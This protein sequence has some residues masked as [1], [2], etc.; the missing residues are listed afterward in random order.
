VASCEVKG[1]SVDVTFTNGEKGSFEY[2][3]VA[4]GREPVIA[5]SVL[6]MWHCLD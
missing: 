2:V 4:I 1:D 6:R 5:V 3:L